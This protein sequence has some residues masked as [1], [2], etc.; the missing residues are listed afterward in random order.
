[1]STALG[2][3]KKFF[4]KVKRVVDAEKNARIIVTKRDTQSSLV[5]EHDGCAMAVAAKRQYH[6]DGVIVSRSTAYLIKG[7]QAR[8]FNLPPSTSREIVSFDRGGGF[9][10]GEYEISKPEPSRRLGARAERGGKIG[11]ADK[12]SGD[13]N[14]PKRFRHLTTNIRH[15]LG[16]KKATA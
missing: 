9:D 11:G 5:K 1:M 13:G 12:R 14:L 4:P 6:L 10:E 3:V 2:I 16:G 7:S 8:R 15:V